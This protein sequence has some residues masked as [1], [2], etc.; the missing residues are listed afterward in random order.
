MDATPSSRQSGHEETRRGRRVYVNG[1]L[2]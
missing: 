1:Y 2:L